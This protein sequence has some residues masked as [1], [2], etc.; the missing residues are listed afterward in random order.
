[1]E[2]NSNDN[3]DH[4]IHDDFPTQEIIHTQIPTGY[5]EQE[6]SERTLDSSPPSV[7]SS[8]FTQQTNDSTHTSFNFLSNNSR[9]NDTPSLS[10]HINNQ[11]DQALLTDR[12]L[13]SNQSNNFFASQNSE[14]QYSQVSQR[15]Q[16]QLLAQGTKNLSYVYVFQFTFF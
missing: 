12:M 6:Q 15:T 10:S 9:N 1:M 2:N 7:H 14:T 4:R 3:N 5:Q 8:Q 13:T 11:D 16:V